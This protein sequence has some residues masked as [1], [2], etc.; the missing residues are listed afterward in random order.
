MMLK[1]LIE[2]AATPAVAGPIQ[3]IYQKAPS[4]SSRGDFEDPSAVGNNT[5]SS[6]KLDIPEINLELRSEAIVAKTRKLKAIWSP[7]FAQD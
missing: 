3:V 5:D 4:D 1:V 7:E 2:T 6:T